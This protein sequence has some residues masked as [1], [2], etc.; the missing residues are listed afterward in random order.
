MPILNIHNF[1][2]PTIFISMYRSTQ[3]LF[4]MLESV[5]NRYKDIDVLCGSRF[6][7]NFNADP[8]MI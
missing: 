4:K 2:I 3:I 1:I 6:S 5:E 7:L 8:A